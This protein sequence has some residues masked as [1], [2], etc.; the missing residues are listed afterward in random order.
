MVRR[1]RLLL[2]SSALLLLIGGLLHASAFNKVLS[3]LAIANLQPFA[4]NSLKILWLA[5]STTSIALAAVF[6]FI[7]GRPSAAKRSV[8]LLLALIPLATAVLIYIFMGSFIGGHIM[9]LSGLLATAGGSQ[10]RETNRLSGLTQKPGE[11]RSQSLPG[12]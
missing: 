5:D 2:A 9:L 8:V 3:A 1:P 7:A 4:A 12:S 6:G 10:Q 11:D